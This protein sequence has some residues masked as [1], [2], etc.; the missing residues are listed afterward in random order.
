MNE[1]KFVTLCTLEFKDGSCLG[2]IRAQLLLVFEF[3]LVW[4]I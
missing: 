1:L 2:I 4:K 3:L